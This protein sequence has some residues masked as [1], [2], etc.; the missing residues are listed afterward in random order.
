[1]WLLFSHE[2]D[3]DFVVRNGD[4]T[5]GLR[6]VC[7]AACKDG[8]NERCVEDAGNVGKGIEVLH[9]CLQCMGVGG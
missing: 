2:S 8:D 7:K 9:V 1:M 6:L 5:C 3:N 4:L